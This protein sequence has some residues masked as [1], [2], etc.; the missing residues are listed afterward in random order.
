MTHHLNRLDMTHPDQYLVTRYDSETTSGY[1]AVIYFKTVSCIEPH[2][3]R[4]LVCMMF[5]E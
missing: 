1:E 3:S 4:D 2:G 5:Y